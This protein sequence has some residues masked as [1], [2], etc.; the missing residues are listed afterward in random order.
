MAKSPSPNGQF[1]PGNK[2]GPGNPHA[3]RT[4]QL[5]SALLESLTP[6]KWQGIIDGLVLAATSGDMAAIRL[7]M[8]YS[9]GAPLPAVCPDDLDGDEYQRHLAKPTSTQRYFMEQGQ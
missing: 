7:I 6:E 8:S 5:R 9:I 3:R 1:Q 2:G 4:A